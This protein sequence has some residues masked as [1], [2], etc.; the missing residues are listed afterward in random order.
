MP[1]ASVAGIVDAGLEST[2]PAKDVASRTGLT[3]PGYNIPI[4]NH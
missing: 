2:I 4:T 3:D 1:G